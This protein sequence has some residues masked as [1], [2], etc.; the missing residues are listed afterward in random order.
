MSDN[1]RNPKLSRLPVKVPA[2][3]ATR[4]SSSYLPPR[5][6]IQQTLPEQKTIEK[7][8]RKEAKDDKQQTKKDHNHTSKV[9]ELVCRLALF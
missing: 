6:S 3:S 1:N 8:S 4:K 5:S 9:E 7:P 2:T